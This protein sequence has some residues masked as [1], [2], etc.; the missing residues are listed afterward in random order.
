[1]KLES[2][3]IAVGLLG[4]SSLAQ[5][6]AGQYPTTSISRALSLLSLTKTSFTIGPHLSIPRYHPRSILIPR[7]GGDNDGENTFGF[8]PTILP[9]RRIRK[10][11]RAIWSGW[12]YEWI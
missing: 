8:I 10:R 5:N 4:S 3:F 7:K 6:V 9:G 12:L 1:M 2:A 11:R